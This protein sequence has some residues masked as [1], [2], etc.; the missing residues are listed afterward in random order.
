MVLWVI[1]QGSRPNVSNKRIL[2]LQN[3]SQY[4]NGVGDVIYKI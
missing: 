4:K 1:L 3:K 2:C